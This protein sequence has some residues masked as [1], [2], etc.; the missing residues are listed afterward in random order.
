MH[1]S[2]IVE[3]F[4]PTKVIRVL[5]KDKPCF[6]GDCRGAFDIKQEAHLPWSRDRSRVN[7]VEFVRYQRSA[8]EVYAEAGSQFS[9]RSWDVLMSGQC[10]HR[11][12]YT[13]K[14]A[15]S[16][17]LEF[18]LVSYTSYSWGGGELV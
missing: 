8:N 5:N 4:V 13:L 3:H 1:L 12:C 6:N 2:L 7:W 10:T 15:G 11:W 14:S 18:G 17:W 16:V 9:V